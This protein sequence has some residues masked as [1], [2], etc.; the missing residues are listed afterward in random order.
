M[1]SVKAGMRTLGLLEPKMG[2]FTMPKSFSSDEEI[3][4]HNLVKQMQRE[5]LKALETKDFSR[6]DDLKSAFL[7]AGLEVRMSK[8]S[9][10]L[11]PGP[12]FDPSKLESLK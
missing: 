9:V 7:A 2:E 3:K 1:A 5:R 8:D 6:I 12:D 4:L 11:I 10:E